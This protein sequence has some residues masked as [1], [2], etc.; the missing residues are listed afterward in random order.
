MSPLPL[1]LT[2][3]SVAGRDQFQLAAVDPFQ[4]DVAAAAGTQGFQAA[5]AD[6]HDDGLAL[7]AEAEHPVAAAQRTHVQGIALDHGF[8][9]L[10]LAFRAADFHARFALGIDQHLVRAFQL[11]PG[12][13]RHRAVFPGRGEVGLLFAVRRAGMQGRDAQRDQGNSGAVGDQLI[14]FDCHCSGLVML[15]RYANR[16]RRRAGKRQTRKNGEPTA[17]FRY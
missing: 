9:L 1:A 11:N 12:E 16:R 10:D 2:I 7:L 8:Q 3:R 5:G 17:F 6:F 15:E 4:L 14:H 13:G